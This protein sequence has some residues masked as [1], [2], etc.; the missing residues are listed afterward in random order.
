MGGG[1]WRP[2]SKDL[3]K[4][5]DFIVSNPQSW[6]NARKTVGKKYSMGGES[7]VRPPRGYD[8][9]TLT[10]PLVEKD[11]L[12]KDFVWEIALPDEVVTDGAALQHMLENNFKDLAPAMD[13]LCAALDLDF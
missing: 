6:L 4:I 9:S 11:L 1:V 10:D 3:R 13:Y 12:W 8:T 5:R 2:D 7:L